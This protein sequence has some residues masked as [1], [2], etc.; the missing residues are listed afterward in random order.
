ME[1]LLLITGLLL[2]FVAALIAKEPQA[3]A[4]NWVSGKTWQE[5][6]D[7][8]ARDQRAY[9]YLSAVVLG[10]AGFMLL[11]FGLVV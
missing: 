9:A 5:N 4:R 6:P 8:A 3:A 10:L 1:P 11:L 7:R 2:L